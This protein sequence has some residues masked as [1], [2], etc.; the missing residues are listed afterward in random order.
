VRRF[1]ETRGSARRTWNVYDA[2]GVLS[3]LRGVWVRRVVSAAR[4]LGRI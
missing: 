1:D 2:G 4:I 3:F